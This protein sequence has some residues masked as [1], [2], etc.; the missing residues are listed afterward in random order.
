MKNYINKVL[1]LGGCVL[2]LSSC[3]DNSWN[4][5]LDGFEEPRPTDVQ[6]IE[7][8]LTANDYKTL[9]SNSVNKAL[10]GDDNAKA[11]SA[12][13]TQ[14][15]FTDVITPQAYIPALLKDPKFPYFT[16]SDGS[17]IKVTYKIA[18]DLPQEV[19]DLAAAAKYT[20]SEADY[21][22]VWGSDTDFANAFAP[23]H[24]A[25]RSLPGILKTALPDAQAGDYVIVNY[26]TAAQ[27]PNFGSSETPEFKLSSVLGSLT[28]MTKGDEITVN[29]YV[30]ALSTQGPVVTD[31]TGSV[32][33]Y[34]PTNNSTLKLGDQISL[35][36]TLDSYNYGW[37]IARGSTPEVMGTQ[38]VKNPTAKN[39]TAAE[40]DQF[41]KDAMA[42][43]A[44]PIAPIYS[45]FTGSVIVDGNYVNIKVDG[46]TVQLSPYGASNDLK[47]LF[48]NGETV[49]LEG[50]VVAVASRGKFLNVIVTKVGDKAISTLSTQAVG[51]RAGVSVASTNENAVYKFD[52]SKWAVA[53]STVVLSHADYQAMGQ[54]HDNL[55]GTVPAD[56]LP[57][58]LKGKYPY[59]VADDAMFVVY[60]YYN[61]SETVTKCDQYSYDGN[62]WTLNNGIVT[63]TAQFVRSKGVWNYDPSVVITLAPGRG[64]ALSTLYFQTCVDWVKDNVAD[65][66][67]YVS[68]YGNNEYYC[69]TSAYQGNVDL[70]PSAAKTQY[71][72]YNSMTDDEVVALEKKRFE[73][74]VM[75]AALAKLH[76]DL[77]PVDGVDVTV[78]IHFGAYYGTT[79]REPNTT[80]VFKVTAPGTFEFVSCTWNE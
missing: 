23:S 58:F 75:P 54:S 9:A 22:S 79:I 30:A 3:D 27:D 33:V 46:A 1:L 71:A 64:Q 43:G 57:I 60:Y 36:S 63:E 13:G 51:S 28:N 15:Y 74:E 14:G 11:L 56:Y 12:V 65:G 42:S 29:G 37:Q 80:I 47:A 61:G 44:K 31:A 62:A 18:T 10:A 7:Y 78:T 41:V 19:T 24:T 55:S 52:G 25:S 2:A 6:T 4:D 21:Q 53:P 67:A 45:K 5:K 40:M 72:G 20:V 49:T 73:T 38:S 50:Y 39:W 17:A 70:R 59:A 26:N 35:S 48:K 16:L 69:G 34:A 76:P 66:P 68:S 32:F 8:T 77:K